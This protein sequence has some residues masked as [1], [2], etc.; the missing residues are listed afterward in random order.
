MFPSSGSS[1]SSDGSRWSSWMKESINTI[2]QGATE[3]GSA[4]AETT[5]E[6]KGKVGD[7]WED[8]TNLSSF[9]NFAKE[10]STKATNTVMDGYSKM[11]QLPTA[12]LPIISNP[13]QPNTGVYIVVLGVSSEAG[14]PA[15][16]CSRSCC[17]GGPSILSRIPVVPLSPTS[18]AQSST[19]TATAPSPTASASA[20]PSAAHVPT[21][22]HVGSGLAIPTFPLVYKKNGSHVLH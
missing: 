13:A 16:G 19:P 6:V 9:S 3:F 7:F 21:A 15:F 17:K 11:V 5:E 2:K 14:Y 22:T 20:A 4:V 18:A 12:I 8:D 10:V 1:S